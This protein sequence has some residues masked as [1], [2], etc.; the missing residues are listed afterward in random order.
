M[1]FDSVDSREIR[2]QQKAVSVAA[3]TREGTT[4]VTRDT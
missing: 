2:V 4:C 1:I 3:K